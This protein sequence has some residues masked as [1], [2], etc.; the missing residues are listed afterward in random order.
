LEVLAAPKIMTLDNTEGFVQV[1]AVVPRPTGVTN[2]QNGTSVTTTDTDVGLILRVQPRVGPDGLIQMN[3]D[4]T[5]SRVGPEEEGI[6]IGFANTDTG[7]V[8]DRQ[9]SNVIRSP[10]ILTT[11]AQSVITAYDGQ[12]VVYGGLITKE[13]TQ[14]SRRVP[15]ISDIP[16]IGLFFRY[17]LEIERRTELLVVMTPKLVTSEADLEEIKISESGRMSWCLADV[18]EMYGNYGLSPGHG[19][20]G[21]AVPPVIYPDLAPTIDDSPMHLD[22]QG[23]FDGSGGEMM[24]PD[25]AYPDGSQPA[26]QGQPVI[27]EPLPPGYEVG[28]YDQQFQSGAVIAPAPVNPAPVGPAPTINDPLLNPPPSRAIPQQPF[29]PPQPDPRLRPPR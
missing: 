21:P 22:P 26:Y 10:Q 3:I 17:D 28:A 4:A 7:G 24:M 18:L 20:W 5:R 14:N 27:T 8:L 11:R 29:P 9:E 2:N 13:R 19:L 15:W 16:I 6:P 25:Q 1:G 12:T 23:M